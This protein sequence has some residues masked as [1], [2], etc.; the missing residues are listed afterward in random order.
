[1]LAATAI[2][3]VL[4]NGPLADWYGSLRDA[5]PFD[6]TVSLPTDR[7]L[8]LDLTLAQWAADGVLALFFFVVGLELKRE[9]IVGELRRP[10]TAIVPI[11]AAIGGVVVPATTY[12]VV[13]AHDPAGSVQGWAVPTATDIAFALA[14]LSVVGRRLPSSL[15]AFLLTL[16]IVDDLIAI[17]IIAVVFPQRVDMVWLIPAAMTLGLVRFLSNRRVTSIA[18]LFPLAAFTWLCVHESGIHATIAGV[19]LGLVVPATRKG[20]ETRTPVER[21]EHI[22]GPVSAVF[23]IPVFALFAAGVALD[24][25]AV[26]AAFGSPQSRGIILGLMVGKPVGIILATALIAGLTRAT[27]PRGVS[28]WDVVAVAT[29]G[30]I[31]FTVSLLIG[32]L[33]FG[34]NSVQA[35][36]AKAAVL[37]ASIASATVGAVLLAWRDRHYGKVRSRPSHR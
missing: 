2:A 37:L 20:R 1:M 24:G 7:S 27:L 30:G 31:G 15:R 3:L 29:I 5:V 13:N 12:L 34:A 23:A 33:A 10:A 35:D 18:L 25:S 21:A 22:W 14:V 19:A 16:A 17:T 8:H 11:I 26:S 28:W 4:A 6:L 36:H 32:D 9:M